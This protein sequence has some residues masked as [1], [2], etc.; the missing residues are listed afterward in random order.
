[1]VKVSLRLRPAFAY[2]ELFWTFHCVTFA[3]INLVFFVLIFDS[4]CNLVEHLY[5]FPAQS[6]LC[7]ARS[8]VS[9]VASVAFSIVLSELNNGEV[10]LK[11]TS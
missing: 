3:Q 4:P 7:P 2:Y 11:R 9:L 8:H 5:T 1:M 6:A 10:K